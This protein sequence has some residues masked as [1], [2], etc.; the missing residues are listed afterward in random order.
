MD[1]ISYKISTININNITNQNKLNALHHFTKTS[2]S[3]IL[4]LQEVENDKITIPGFNIIFNVDHSRRGTAIALKNYIR[5]SQVERSL[6]S[7]LISLRIHDMVSIIN[8]YAPSGTQNRASR[9][10]FFNSTISYYL[11]H[12]AEHV[13]LGGDFNSVIHSKDATGESNFSLS[14]KNTVKQAQ[15]TDVWDFL[16]KGTTQYTY[17]THNSASRIDRLYVSSGLLKDLRHIDTHVC[18]FTNHHALTLRLCLPSLGRDAGRG[19]WSIR[20][21]VLTQDNMNEFQLKWDYWTRQRR[22]YNSWMHWWL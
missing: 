6:D 2:E 10:D 15:L 9:E 16:R 18:S 17:I 21:H 14:L 22:N 20:P 8:V 12:A 11:R 19:Y 1:S 4:L 3:D 5:F 7:R 13:I